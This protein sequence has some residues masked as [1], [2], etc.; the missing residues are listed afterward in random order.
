MCL[1]EQSDKTDQAFMGM[2]GTVK[3]ELATFR[4]DRVISRAG[5]RTAIVTSADKLERSK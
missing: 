2:G 1:S 3:K 4:G 5:P